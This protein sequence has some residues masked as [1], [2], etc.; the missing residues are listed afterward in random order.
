[1]LASSL[2]AGRCTKKLFGPYFRSGRWPG[3]PLASGCEYSFTH[4][5]Q[6]RVFNFF[7]KFTK[8]SIF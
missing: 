3:M 1:M 5:L 4:Y 8:A 2:T 7:Y 6:I